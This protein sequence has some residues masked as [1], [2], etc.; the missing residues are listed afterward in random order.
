M[1]SQSNNK[2]DK[3]K[4]KPLGKMGIKL[5]YCYN[6]KLIETIYKLNGSKIFYVRTNK[7]CSSDPFYSS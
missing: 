4:Y 3:E 2:P 5:Y 7:Q 6:M 1:N